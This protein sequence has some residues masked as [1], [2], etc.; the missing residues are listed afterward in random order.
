MLVHTPVGK[1]T[2]AL[3]NPIHRDQS[4]YVT[5]RGSGSPP[6]VVSGTDWCRSQ[7]VL[8]AF[9]ATVA[10]GVRHFRECHSMRLPLNQPLSTFLLVLS[11]LAII[12]GI[13]LV[14]YG[15]VWLLD[16]SPSPFTAVAI[17]HCGRRGHHGRRATSDRKTPVVI[18]KGIDVARPDLG[19]IR[20]QLGGPL[21][22]AQP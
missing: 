14:E 20:R 13:A 22:P 2:Q 16:R 11:I 15:H 12:L 1:V 8:G 3:E 17:V 21:R 18:A 4:A 10:G 7:R 19:D 5:I 9:L 6:I